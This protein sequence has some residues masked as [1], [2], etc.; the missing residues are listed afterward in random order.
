M[1]ESRRF[2]GLEPRHRIPIGWRKAPPQIPPLVQ[3]GSKASGTVLF[4]CFE[5]LPGQLPR[6]PAVLL[7]KIE[8]AA[9]FRKRG[10][11]LFEKR[12]RAYTRRIARRNR[13]TVVARQLQSQAE[14]SHR[15]ALL[16]LRQ[17][18]PPASLIDMPFRN[19]SAKNLR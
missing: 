12:L 9:R 11:E 7:S 17:P 19:D 5:R 16:P 10:V 6:L 8:H 2:G 1:R 4:H 3:P 15:L 13:K 14:I 18:Q